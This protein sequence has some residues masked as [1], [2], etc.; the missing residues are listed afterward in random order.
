L[1]IWMV[2]VPP[3]DWVALLEHE[4]SKI[5]VTDPNDD[6]WQLRLGLKMSTVDDIDP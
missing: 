3:H 1:G 6:A 2:V 5:S 4:S